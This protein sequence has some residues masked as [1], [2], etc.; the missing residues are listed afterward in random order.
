MRIEELKCFNGLFTHPDL[1]HFDPEWL[2]EVIEGFSGNVLYTFEQISKNWEDNERWAVTVLIRDVFLPSLVKANI[3]QLAS[4]YAPAFMLVT[5]V[6]Q[7]SELNDSHINTE[8]MR[9]NGYG[10]LCL[11]G[12][13]DNRHFVSFT[14]YGMEVKG[15]AISFACSE[16]ALNEWTATICMA[17][18]LRALEITRERMGVIKFRDW[19]CYGIDELKWYCSYLALREIRQCRDK[20]GLAALNKKF[21][22]HVTEFLS[23]IIEVN[24]NDEDTKA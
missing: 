15:T 18:V 17:I 3:E 22:A 13:Y 19:D 8:D 24:K 7:Y 1:N 23:K 16:E 2:D 11:V 20:D 10:E 9:L 6:E 12:D 21:D 5:D 4:F 14:E